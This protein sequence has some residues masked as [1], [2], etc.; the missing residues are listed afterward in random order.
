VETNRLIQSDM[1]KEMA[2]ALKNQ[3]RLIVKR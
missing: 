2:A 3:L 1:P